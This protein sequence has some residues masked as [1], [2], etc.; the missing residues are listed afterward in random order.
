VKRKANKIFLTALIVIAAV[1]AC[2]R[3]FYF[4][5]FSRRLY[6]RDPELGWR[7]KRNF[8]Y[9]NRQRDSEGRPYTVRIT[10]NEHGFRSW[11]DV[12]SKK[13]KIF[14]IGDS[15]T[16]DPFVSDEDAYFER[17]GQLL[18]AEVFAFGAGGYGT[19]QELLALR[20]YAG[21]IR[22]D[23]VVLQMCHNDLD[24]NSY[25]LEA[26]SITTDQKNFRPYWHKE[27]IVFRYPG[28][29]IYKFLFKYSRIFR[30]FDHVTQVVRFRMY[31][32]CYPPDK[33]MEEKARTDELWR[34][35]EHI[36]KGLLAEM[37]RSLPENVQ[38]IAFMDSPYRQEWWAKLI[39]SAGFIVLPEPALAVEAAAREGV[40]VRVSDK[41]HWSPAGHRIAGEAL[42]R[43]LAEIIKY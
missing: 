27:E 10:T 18:G 36:T 24:N 33:T 40:V 4:M 43:A 32:G 15:Y 23:V 28:F 19:L 17:A 41:A 29:H 20:K 7:P 12:N 1:A 42:A 35:A 37:A 25:L 38:K 13:I 14:F 22:P 34:Q 6:E 8:S 16:G 9:V 30:W 3:V 5:F 21:I 11:G 26:G 2:D 39:T 31:N